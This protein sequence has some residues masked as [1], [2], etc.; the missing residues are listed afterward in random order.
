MAKRGPVGSCNWAILLSFH[1][2]LG[3]ICCR[4]ATIAVRNLQLRLCFCR[5]VLLDKS[6]ALHIHSYDRQK[7]NYKEKRSSLL[8]S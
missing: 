6:P 2:A 1:N 8:Q 5:N 7:D 4:V 3:N